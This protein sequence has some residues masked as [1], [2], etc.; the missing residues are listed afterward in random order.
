ML[1]HL[2]RLSSD[3]YKN[4][5]IQ[6]G[7]HDEFLEKLTSYKLIVKRLKR[8][9]MLQYVGSTDA[10]DTH[11]TYIYDH[12]LSW[13]GRNTSIKHDEVRLVLL[14]YVSSLSEIN[15]IRGREILQQFKYK[16]QARE[17]RI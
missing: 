17:L 14:S 8:N 1:S 5:G 3:E 7:S 10:F 12:S 15:A 6:L 4:V 9:T 13:Y 16:H 2:N 11:S